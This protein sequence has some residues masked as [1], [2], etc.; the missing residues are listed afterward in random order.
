MQ[1]TCCASG[2][3]VPQAA[4]CLPRQLQRRSGPQAAHAVV[5]AQVIESGVGGLP[6]QGSSAM[7]TRRCRAVPA[8]RPQRM[9]GAAQLAVLGKFL[10]VFLVKARRTFG[11]KPVDKKNMP[12]AYHRCIIPKPIQANRKLYLARQIGIAVAHG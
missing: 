11:V 12:S 3:E 6:M 4:Q 7:P 8:A 10:A 5:P 1:A 9:C 2:E